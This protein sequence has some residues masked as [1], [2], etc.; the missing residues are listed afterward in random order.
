VFVYLAMEILVFKLNNS[1]RLSLLVQKSSSHPYDM[2]Q[3]VFGSIYRRFNI[4][5]RTIWYAFALGICRI[6]A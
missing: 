3:L 6:E 1:V 4:H 2:K 5:I